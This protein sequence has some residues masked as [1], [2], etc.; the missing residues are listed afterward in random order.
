MEAALVFRLV[1]RGPRS[2]RRAWPADIRARHELGWR[3]QR[4]LAA[5]G[6]ASYLVVAAALLFPFVIDDV[7]V[8]PGNPR[9]A[10]LA[11][12]LA[13]PVLTGMLT[14]A[15]GAGATAAA[16]GWRTVVVGATLHLVGAVATL[17]VGSP[18]AFF[19]MHYLIAAIVAQV[20]VGIVATLVFAL[21]AA[22]LPSIRRS[23]PPGRSRALP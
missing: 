6:A 10:M 9:Q 22:A 8:V 3:D 18:L 20:A 16:G 14:A 5:L 19:F 2:R 7:T 4:A 23:G 1:T 12:V 21:G 15:A 13:V 11:I 17:L